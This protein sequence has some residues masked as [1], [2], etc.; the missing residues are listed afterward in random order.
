MTHQ[1]ADLDWRDDRIPVSR[2]FDDPYF[3]L[4]DGLAETEHVFLQGNHIATRLHAPLSIAELGFGTGLNFLATWALHRASGSTS[5]LKF[6]TFEA[7]PMTADDM[8]A[9]LAAFPQLSDLAAPLV[10]MVRSGEWQIQSGPVSLQVI[11]GDAR[12]TLPKWEGKADAWYLDGFS[13][14][15]N[16]ELW[17]ADMMAQV[18]AHTTAG[19]TLATYTAAGHVRRALAEAGFTVTRSPGFGRKRH[20]TSAEMPN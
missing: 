17:G 5:P 6:T 2:Q 1:T 19:G 3:S 10:K 9:A 12:E 4:E 18:A 13:P 7:F 11:V 20:M 8:A 14:A 16:P 15:K